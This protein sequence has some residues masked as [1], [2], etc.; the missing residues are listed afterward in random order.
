MLIPT[1]GRQIAHR[2]YN[3]GCRSL[4]DIRKGKGGVKLSSVQEI[5][6]QFYD[7][8][9]VAGEQVTIY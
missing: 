1:V 7:G 2:W 8:M 5:G 3:A 9:S 4:D 6:L